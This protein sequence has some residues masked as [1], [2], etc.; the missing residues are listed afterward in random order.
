M[1]EI[2]HLIGIKGSLAE[3]YAAIGTIEGLRRW[4]TADTSGSSEV[5][6]TIH[7]EFGGHGAQDMKVT[8]LKN[9][10][11]GALGVHQACRAMEGMGRHRIYF[12]V[13]GRKRSGLSALH[14]SELERGDRHAGLLH[15]E[16]GG[17]LSGA[18]GTDR[19]RQR[20]AVPKRSPKSRIA[21]RSL[22]NH[23]MIHPERFEKQVSRRSIGLDLIRIARRPRDCR[24]AAS[25][26]IAIAI[27]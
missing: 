16:M 7:F 27:A 20:Q 22:G 2:N 1:A 10:C 25:N 11:T 8:E 13:E 19:E 26:S 23:R 21:D 18:Q 14:P 17:L 15:D 3:V 24:S 4:W 5:G 6:G 12:R 9:Q